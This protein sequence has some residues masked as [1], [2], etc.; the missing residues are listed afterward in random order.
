VLVIVV[1]TAVRCVP[2]VAGLAEL[3]GSQVPDWLRAGS[4][5]PHADPGSNEA[6]VA[7]IL[8]VA[9]LVA[10][11]LVV[12]GLLARRSWAW[13]MAIVSSGVILAL[14]LGWWWSGQPRD[15]SMLLNV[16]AVFYLNQQDVRLA[17]RSRQADQP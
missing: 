13:V 12:I 11:I 5:I 16:I 10:S 7:A 15:V 17:L 3:S 6:I 14:D 8:L 1:I 2:L 9:L 4:P